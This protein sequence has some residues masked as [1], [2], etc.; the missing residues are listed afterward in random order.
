MTV[1]SKPITVSTT[2]LRT[3]L[4]EERDA[5]FD[6]YL[7]FRGTQPG[8]CIALE[9]I[10]PTAPKHRFS[11]S[12]IATTLLPNGARQLL[13]IADEE[14]V[15]KGTFI[16]QNA[17]HPHVAAQRTAD[18]WTGIKTGEGIKDEDV[19]AR[20]AFYIDLDPQRPRD[21]SATAAEQRAAFELA[22]RVIEALVEILGD[23]RPVG[24]G[25]SGNGIQIHI[26]L[27]S[28]PNT[29]ELTSLVRETLSSSAA[30]FDTAAVKVDTTVCDPRRVCPAFGTVK[31][32]GGDHRGDG[33]P[34]EQWRP[35][36]RSGFVCHEDVRRLSLDELRA[37]RDGL[38][39][40]RP[41]QP[42]A[43]AVAPAA[44]VPSTPAPT[45]TGK[46]SKSP[47][48]I[49]KEIDIERVS[50]F[51][52]LGTGASMTCPGCGSTS[53]YGVIPGK[54]LVKCH[55][56]RC[57][58]KG[59]PNFPGVRGGIDLVVEAKN[60]DAHAAVTVLANHFGFAAPPAPKAK[61]KAPRP[62]A[63]SGAAWE[64]NLIYDETGRLKDWTA[65]A[66]LILSNDPA[67]S[68][69]LAYDELRHAIIFKGPPPPG[70]LKRKSGDEWRDEDDVACA[71]WLQTE[72]RLSLSVLTVRSVIAL[73][74]HAAKFHP[75]RDW[76]ESLK[77][78][79]TKR[80]ESWLSTYLGV[81]DTPY[82]R[83]VGKWWLIAAVARALEPGCKVD[84]ILVLEG[85][86]GL[87]KSSALRVL[88]GDSFFLEDVRDVG[89]VEAL[90][91]L[92]GKWIVELA[93]LD[94]FRKAESS[95]VKKFLSTRVDN[96]RPSYGRTTIDFPRQ[97]I[98]AGTT[99]HEVYLADETGGRRWW[100]VKCTKIR[101]DAIALDREQLW[102]EAV[103]LYRA[104]VHWWPETE[105]DHAL[106]ALEQEDRSSEDPWLKVIR[107]WVLD[108]DEV[109][110]TDLLISAL[111]YEQSRVADREAK[112]VAAVL[113]TLGWVRTKRR[114][115]D[116]RQYRA[117]ERGPGA[118]PKKVTAE[119]GRPASTT[120][121]ASEMN[122]AFSFSTPGIAK[123]NAQAPVEIEDPLDL[124]EVS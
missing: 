60:V 106:C 52:G 80:A 119:R 120:P 25:A 107:E 46:P 41:A 79:G 61:R 51:L 4:A 122:G 92:A 58:D 20:R 65:N 54:N 115:K 93:E 88:T 16:Q 84:T 39:A 43:P 104:N 37:L 9:A 17:L 70:F 91:Q 63:A 103:A 59:L 40:R 99:N 123:T 110:T 38:R 114:D 56:Q 75:V 53:G 7:R 18:A 2:A 33:I 82:A 6:R 8:E 13:K 76:L 108:V 64:Q 98:F 77:W 118:D 21:T 14:I 96:Y 101:L 124:L 111:G 35:H 47:W 81:A 45:T 57:V 74:A 68:G 32:K 49:A 69:V 85:P 100:P 3:A 94:A 112:R 34:R 71:N 78:D 87:F 89:G 66:T 1:H 95:T 15:P 10:G 105:E 90:K 73:V 55:H 117:F 44:P 23:D 12:M 24:L 11:A 67:W 31:R 121:R 102:A 48:E 83:R 27:D 26:A 19:A 36:R 42:P 116:G 113:R 5:H 72:W 28:L 30:L 86:Q 50:D 29:A 62:P 97:C 22:D 109:T